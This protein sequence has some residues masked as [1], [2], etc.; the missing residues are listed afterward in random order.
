MAEVILWSVF[1]AVIVSS[2]LAG[3]EPFSMLYLEGLGPT[4]GIV[5]YKRTEQIR[6][7][8]DEW[9]KSC[10]NTSLS[11]RIESEQADFK[12][13]YTSYPQVP[14]HHGDNVDHPSI[15]VTLFPHWSWNQLEHL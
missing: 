5:C 7:V 12:L 8:L 11:R 13:R 3:H 10:G 2:L 4:L 9:Y 1:S 6:D 14:V 15:S